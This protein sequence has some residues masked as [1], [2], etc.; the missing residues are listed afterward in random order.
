MA[1]L[2]FN[3]TVELQNI[4]PICHGL[5]LFCPVLH[6][7]ASGGFVHFEPVFLTPLLALHSACV[8]IFCDQNEKA[9]PKQNKDDNHKTAQK[10][11]E[12]QAS[13]GC[14]MY[15]SFMEP[16]KLP[17]TFENNLSLCSLLKINILFY[18]NR[19]FS[20]L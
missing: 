2:Y 3:H 16:T 8:S 11:E 7:Y 14:T 4:L 10:G 1:V 18:I 19:Q 13:F 6:V 17:V 5:W 9:L 12:S 15:T 20:Q